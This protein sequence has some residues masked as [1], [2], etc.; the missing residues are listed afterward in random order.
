MKMQEENKYRQFKR[1]LENLIKS[2]ID[3]YS[4]LKFIE[5]NIDIL[6]K[7][8]DD[9]D[10]NN[11]IYFLLNNQD[12]YGIVYVDGDTYYWS[13]LINGFLTKLK[14]VNEKD[15][16]FLQASDFVVEMIINFANS[17]KIKQIIPEITTYSVENKLRAL[18][19]LG[20]NE[21]GYHVK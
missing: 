21:N 14:T 8:D 15:E 1:L 7:K 9:Y 12:V 6:A 19:N 18:K 13:N 16:D 17:E 3:E 11:S 4:A 5:E 10:V 2:G 20:L